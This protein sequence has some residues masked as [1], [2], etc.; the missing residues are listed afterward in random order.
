MWTFLLFLF[1]RLRESNHHHRCRDGA[2]WGWG[3]GAGY[4]FLDT[5]FVDARR[6]VFGFGFGFGFGIGISDIMNT[7]NEKCHMICLQK[8]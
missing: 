2:R 5:R 6:G 3:E 1:W 8:D 7:E 4:S